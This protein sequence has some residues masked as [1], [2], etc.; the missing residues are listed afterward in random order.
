MMPIH[1]NIYTD[2]VCDIHKHTHTIPI[3]LFEMNADA[4]SNISMA[5]E[6]VLSYMGVYT[7]RV[8]KCE[9][10]LVCMS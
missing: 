9:C 5:L 10:V 3:S 7:L 1:E 2:D 8:C 6:S 4:A